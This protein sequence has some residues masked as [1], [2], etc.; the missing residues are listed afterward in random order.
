MKRKERVS[1]EVRTKQT[2]E[3][4]IKAAESVFVRDGYEVAELGEIATMAGRSKGAIYNHFESKEDLFLSLYKERTD[5]YREELERLMSRSSSQKQNV[6][7]LRKFVAGLLEDEAWSTLLIEFK[8]FA[9]RHPDSKERLAKIYYAQMPGQTEADYDVTFGDPGKGSEY[10]SRAVAI[11][12][13]PALLSALV[14]E[15]DFAPAISTRSA[16]KKL[17]T[18]LFDALMKAPRQTDPAR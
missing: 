17:F 8:L 7:I 13:L 4:L 3:L 16:Q 5:A 14:I 1:N 11:Q 9:K 15:R 6:E 10:V 2:R 12:A 18:H